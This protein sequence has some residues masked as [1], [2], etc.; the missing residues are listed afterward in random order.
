MKKHKSFF[1]A[2]IGFVLLGL[3]ITFD[4]FSPDLSGIAGPA[5]MAV[6]AFVIWYSGYLKSREKKS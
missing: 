5:F 1:L 6:G 2:G 4:V 3:L